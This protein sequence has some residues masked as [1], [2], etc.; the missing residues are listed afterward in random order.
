M[1]SAPSFVVHPLHVVRVAEQRSPSAVFVLDD[2]EEED[3][4]G[5][6]SSDSSDDSDV[7]D[8]DL[9]NATREQVSQISTS[10]LLWSRGHEVCRILT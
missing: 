4:K 10:S 1:K 6:D 5:D 9:E 2:A 7:E 3:G 8:L